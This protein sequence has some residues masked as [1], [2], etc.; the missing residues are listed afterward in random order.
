MKK[1]I[2]ER[3][4]I[5]NYLQV[6]ED[7]DTGFAGIV[8]FNNLL[9]YVDNNALVSI[10]KENTIEKYLEKKPSYKELIEKTMK[11]LDSYTIV[12]DK[13]I[14]KFVIS[15]IET[16]VETFKDNDTLE[17][18]LKEKFITNGFSTNTD[19]SFPVK[20]FNTKALLVYNDFLSILETIKSNNNDGYQEL[21]KNLGIKDET[22]N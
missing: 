2:E 3:F 11:E 15:N 1:Y 6:G 16:F 9:Y 5:V 21:I 17:N 8:L 22:K 12:F 10:D 4:K 19:W 13:N 20:E 7:I 14:G 18:N